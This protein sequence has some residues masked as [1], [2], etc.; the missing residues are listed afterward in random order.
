MGTLRINTGR[1]TISRLL[2]NEFDKTDWWEVEKTN[3][4]IMTAKSYGLDDLVI[5]MQNDLK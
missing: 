5:E 2:R 3:E 1:D 4:L